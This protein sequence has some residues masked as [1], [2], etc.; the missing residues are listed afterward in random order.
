MRSFTN[1]TAAALFMCVGIITAHADPTCWSVNDNCYDRIDVLDR[2]IQ[3]DSARVQAENRTYR[4]VPGH[5]T[6]ITSEAE[7]S[8]ILDSFGGTVFGRMLGGFQASGSIEPDGGWQWITGEPFVFTNWAAGQP[9]NAGGNED[10]LYWGD[11][12]PPLAW[13]DGNRRVFRP[14]YIIEYPDAGL[15][16]NYIDSV[17]VA[18]QN[19]NGSVELAALRLTRTG[20]PQVVIKDSKTTQP[21]RAVNFF[22]RNKAWEPIAVGVVADIT[23]NGVEEL[24]VLAKNNKTDAVRAQFKDAKT[25]A[26]IKNLRFS[27]RSTY[28]DLVGLS[29]IN[30]NGSPDIAVA[31][32][33]S[34]NHPQV[35]VKDSQ[36]GSVVSV[37]PFLGPAWNP[38]GLSS[39]HVNNDG[40]PELLL[41]AVN[42]TNHRVLA[43]A[44]DALTGALFQN[45]N[46]PR[47]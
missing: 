7:Q 21:L 40:I 9:D 8:F 11:S 10:V 24:V 28:T 16:G 26:W 34:N 43:Q 15:V 45:M 46:F 38:K 13:A 5:L 17:P 36:T 35:I 23:G 41:M 22:S 30:G 44:K 14:G 47:K 25:K 12:A 33:A 1:L 4:G 3:W 27:A 32:R 20:Q 37:V 31:R 6:T 42:E 29:D 2:Y 19:G 39:V 18:D